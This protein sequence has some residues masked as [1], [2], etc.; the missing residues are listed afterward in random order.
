MSLC[1]SYCI[2]MAANLKQ[3]KFIIGETECCEIIFYN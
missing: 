2:S 3:D 1:K